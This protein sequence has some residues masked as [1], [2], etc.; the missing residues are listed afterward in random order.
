[1]HTTLEVV[2]TTMEVCNPP[3]M[4]LRNLAGV[5]IITSVLMKILKN[6]TKIPT[7]TLIQMAIPRIPIILNITT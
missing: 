2:S 7:L 3:M 6:A 1:M 5:N 4:G